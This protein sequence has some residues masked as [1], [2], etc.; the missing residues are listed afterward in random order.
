MKQNKLKELLADDQL[1]ETFKR[2]FVSESQSL[3]HDL[4][5]AIKSDDMHAIAILAHSLKS[6]LAYFDDEEAYIVAKRM[7]EVAEQH[8][9]G[10]RVLSQLALKLDS[11]VGL[12]IKDIQS[13]RTIS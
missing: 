7:E 13:A 11:L 3:L 1:I 4:Q 2:A 10:E 5:V 6:Q 9:E 12:I 8:I